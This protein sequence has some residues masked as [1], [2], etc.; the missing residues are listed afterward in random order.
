[1]EKEYALDYSVKELMA[2]FLSR[3]LKDGETAHLGA[4]QPIPRAAVLLAH[5]SHGPNM[6]ISQS[7]TVSNLIHE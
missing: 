2:T 5:L 1:M 6:R 4:N 7:L 3:D